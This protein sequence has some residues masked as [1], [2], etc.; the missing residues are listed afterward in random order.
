MSSGILDVSS[1]MLTTDTFARLCRARDMLRDVPERP[2][3][4]D[5]VA[6]EAAMS[7]FHFI[8]QFTALF[9]DAPSI[10]N[11]GTP[12]SGERVVGAWQ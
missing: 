10:S 2:L 9:G 8:R 1:A 7:P 4:I 11:P 6:R 5:A 12:R 3:T